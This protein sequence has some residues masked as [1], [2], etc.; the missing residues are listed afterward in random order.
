LAQSRSSTTK[1]NAML[2]NLVQTEQ[3]E[4]DELRAQVAELHDRLK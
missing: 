2:P 4:I 1:V 3:R